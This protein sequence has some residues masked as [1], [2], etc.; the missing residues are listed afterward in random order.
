MDIMSKAWG[1]IISQGA[2]QFGIRIDTDQL[3]LFRDHANH[4][5]KWNRKINLTTITDT[6]EMAVKHY[7]DSIAVLKWLPASC[8]L[9]DIGTG[10][11]FPGIPLKII[12]PDIA[13][14]LIDASRKKINFLKDVVRQLKLENTNAYHLRIEDI[15]QTP[16]KEMSFD[17]VISRAFSSLDDFLRLSF[18][19]LKPEG[20]IVAMKGPDISNE[21]KTLNESPY[22][23]IYG[24]K[25]H[26]KD[27]DI[28]TVQYNLPYSGD[29]RSVVIIR[30]S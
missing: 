3:R 24:E 28:Q 6:T 14:S 20:M 27:L 23:D 25:I 22:I 9:I 2:D 4:L 29:G 13:V 15:R 17:V 7:I 10:A 26:V 11:G 1:N 19:L 21:C 8:S 12:R 30:K 5:L 18:P 16:L